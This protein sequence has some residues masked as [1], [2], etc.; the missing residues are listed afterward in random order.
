MKPPTSRLAPIAGA[1]R[2]CP[3]F[4]VPQIATRSRQSAESPG[5]YWPDD[6]DR[7]NQDVRGSA[8]VRPA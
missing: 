1:R 6:S 5:R 4:Q 7:G 8:E 2:T 3:D